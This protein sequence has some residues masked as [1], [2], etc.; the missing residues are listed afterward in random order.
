MVVH[1]I[2]SPAAA[3][4]LLQRPTEAPCRIPC[5]YG[6]FSAVQ[7]L[8]KK[9]GMF[10]FIVRRFKKDPPDLLV[11]FFFGNGGRTCIPVSGLGFPGKCRQLGCVEF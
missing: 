6:R 7:Q 11:P 4:S 9:L 2:F 3:L 1:S 8:E 10:Q 5:R